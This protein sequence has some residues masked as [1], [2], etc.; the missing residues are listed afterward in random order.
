[1]K[2]R[3]CYLFM[4]LLTM[5]ALGGCAG[6]TEESSEDKSSIVVGIQQDIDSLDPHKATAAGT[7]EILFN[8]FEGL[9]KPDE[10]GNLMNAVA[11]DYTISDDGLVYTF[12]LRENVKFHNGETVTAEDVKYSLERVSGLLD[13]TALM[14]TMSTIQ[15]VDII[16]EKTVQVTVGSANTELIY[17]FTA[18]IIPKGS[19]ED[20]SADPIGTGPFSFVSYTPQEGIVVAKNADYWQA[21]LPYLDEVNFKIVNSPDTALLDLQGGS[22]DIYPY[23]TDSQANE[24]QSS[25]Q[26]LSAPSDVVQALYLN[27]DAEPLN[28]VK[29]RQ[30]ICYALD[31]DSVNDY[32]SGGSGTIISSAMLPT[33]KDYYVDLNDVYGTGANIEEAKKLLAE[34]GYPNG[35]DLEIM[36]P[37]NY[38]FHMQT[39]EVVEQQLQA[40]GINATINPVEWS[41]WLDEC[42]NGRKYQATISGITCD[43]TPGYLLNRFQTDSKKNFINFKNSEYDAIY[44]KAQAALD[45]NEKADYYKQLQEML[46]ED[47]GTAFIQ[48]PPITVA[49]SKE[50]TG[51]KFYPIYVQDMSTVQFVK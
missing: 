13:G 43:M 4:A 14:S 27:N 41:T 50:L 25:F 37:S 2:K 34:A 26:I 15:S 35:F 49:V 6:G 19:G 48:V 10:N 46:C 21:G 29:V 44:K 17:S 28:N 1:M 12:T 20:E 45:L 24:L 11:S 31:K 33:L 42:Y 36:V 22:I 16:D 38:E 32:V 9:V 51:Y 3:F 40:A 30:A 5:A 18:A 23:L 39:A 47:A 7:K 8:I